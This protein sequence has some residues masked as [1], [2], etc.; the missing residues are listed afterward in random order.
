[1]KVADFMQGLEAFY[2]LNPDLECCFYA[3]ASSFAFSNHNFEV[4]SIFDHYYIRH[5]IFCN[6]RCNVLGEP[7]QLV[8]WV[9]YH[10]EHVHLTFEVCKVGNL[11]KRLD[12]FLTYNLNYQR[13][14]GLRVL[15]LK[16]NTEI[17]TF[18]L[19]PNDVAIIY[20]MRH[21]IFFSFQF[22][23]DVFVLCISCF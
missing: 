6:S 14:E 10:S 17:P 9:C 3:E 13:L 20:Y 23:L 18:D 4:G 21:F 11:I 12:Y 7:S 22:K 5:S 19:R 8:F 1:M 16:D 15:A 2:H